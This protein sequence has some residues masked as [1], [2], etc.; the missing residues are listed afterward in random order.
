[1]SPRVDKEA[2]QQYTRE[3]YIQ[4]KERI[5]A[6]ERDKYR[7]NRETIRSRRRDLS[8][9]ELMTQNAERERLRYMA[10]RQIVIDAYGGVCSCCGESEPLFLEI[11]HINN[12]GAAHRKE[13]GRSAKALVKWL[14][15]NDFPDGFQLLCA[16]CNQGKKRGGK[17]VCPH[18][19]KSTL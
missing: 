16:N 10:Y 12:N 18:K 3:Y 15:D 8:T 4:N 6:R 9:P 7:Q 13:I 19:L 17:N 11:D 5:K 1:M 2:R 14:L